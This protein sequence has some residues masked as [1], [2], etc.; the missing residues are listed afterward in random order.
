VL[1][2]SPP[3]STP[4]NS[5]ITV[6]VLPDAI[7]ARMPRGFV[8]LS[9][10][11]P[12]LEQYL[13]PDPHHLNPV[14]VALLR[15]LQPGRGSIIRLGGDS[16]DRTW[17]PVRGMRKPAGIDFGLTQRWTAVAR[18]LAADTGDRV[19][20]GINLAAGRRRLA[21]LEARRLVTGVGASHIAA[22]E[23][24]NEPDDYGVTAWYWKHR[25]RVFARP[26]AY[27]VSDYLAQFAGWRS[28][29]PRAVALAGPS[30]ARTQWMSTAEEAELSARRPVDLVT[31]HRYPLRACETKRLAS[32][33][34]TI[35]RLLADSS[36]AGLAGLVA[37]YVSIAHQARRPF[38]L[39]E[40]N[41]VSCQGKLGVSNTFASALWALDTLFTVRAV[42]VDGVN[43]HMLPGSAYQAFAVRHAGKRWSAK[44][45][46]LYYGMLMFV[47][48]FPPGARLLDVSAPAG[49]VKVWATQARSGRLRI[50]LINQDPSSPVTARL[51]LPGARRPVRSQALTAP[52]VSAT[53]D[54]RLA[55]QTFGASTRTGHLKAGRPGPRLSPVR[56]Y[57]SVR[58][59]TGSA[60][61]LTR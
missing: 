38:R 40:L 56:G 49:P 15:G 29:M 25:R 7:G 46:P 32:D 48:A 12:T 54:V 42:G 58:I 31:F 44:V 37:P 2:D 19:V 45:S 10:E 5:K 33:Y 21:A 24:G 51:R 50:V 60:V 9:L 57:Y 4:L 3:R 53:G 27:S 43:V 22:L 36:S 39:D 28:V 52:S 26:S 17:W 20:L 55:G 30:L 23:I 59:P 41:S 18:A 13:G 1:A 6:D 34:P 47:R 61:L 11:Y 8:G 14:F 35:R 16:T